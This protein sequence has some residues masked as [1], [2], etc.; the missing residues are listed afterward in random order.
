MWVEVSGGRLYVSVTG[1]GPPILLIHGWPLDHRIFSLQV[2]P[3]SKNLQVI[4]YDRRGFGESEAPP[5]LRLELDDI[6]R[7]LDELDV[8]S[9]HLL[10]M[11]QGGRI[12]LR[13][14]VTRPER[15][16]SLILQGAVVDGLEVD[17]RG[18]DAVPIAEYANLA[19]CDRLDEVKTR[20]LSHPMMRLGAR[21]KRESR[22]IEK[23]IARYTG[24]DLKH[25]EPDSYSFPCDVPE[26]MSS[27]K[28][29]VLI[30]TGA[31]E[32]E[33]RRAHAAELLH[34]IPNC[35]EVILEES[36]HLSNLTEP[37]RYNETV[38]RFCQDAERTTA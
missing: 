12:A 11:S 1:Q 37:D 15:L 9:V 7:I 14:A 32:T 13:Y 5:D 27:F 24:Q 22:L 10:G 36:S 19:Q 30:L 3:L 21:Y 31:N 16:R 2:R 23:I 34:R 8:D 25:L 26:V 6:D 38:L 20:W 33:T 17:E 18:K 28:N 4:A 29:P 35:R